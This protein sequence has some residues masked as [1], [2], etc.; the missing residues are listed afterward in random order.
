MDTWFVVDESFLLAIGLLV[1]LTAALVV[2]HRLARR[3][4]QREEKRAARSS[5]RRWLR[6]SGL[7]PLDPPDRDN[8]RRR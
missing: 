7:Q 4:A 2:R 8:A 6:E 5:Y 1:L 3:R